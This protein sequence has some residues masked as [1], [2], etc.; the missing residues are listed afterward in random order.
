MRGISTHS[1]ESLLSTV[2]PTLWDVCFSHSTSFQ[3][4][5]LCCWCRLRRGLSWAGVCS[6]VLEV[7]LQ[8][9]V[10]LVAKSRLGRTVDIVEIYEHGW[11]VM[12]KEGSCRLRVLL[13]TSALYYSFAIYSS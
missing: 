7:L 1:T 8:L 6:R 13:R 2:S 4:G 3:T 11:R 12:E 10:L 9:V 5:Y